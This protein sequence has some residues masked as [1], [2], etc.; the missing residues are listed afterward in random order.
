MNPIEVAPSSPVLSQILVTT[1]TA[2]SE[3]FYNEIIKKKKIIYVF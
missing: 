1:L 3:S 2:L